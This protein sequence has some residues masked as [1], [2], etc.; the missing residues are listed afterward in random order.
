MSI[1]PPLLIDRFCRYLAKRVNA[2][3]PLYVA[4]TQD[5]SNVLAH[6]NTLFE[7]DREAAKHPSELGLALLHIATLKNWETVITFLI[8]NGFN[9][10]QPD[11]SGTTPL[12]LATTKKRFNQLLT[13]GADPHAQDLKGR[14]PALLTYLQGWV[15]FPNQ[16]WIIDG[17]PATI[18]TYSKILGR[19][20]S[21]LPHWQ[22]ETRLWIWLTELGLPL[23]ECYAIFGIRPP[24]K[25]KTVKVDFPDELI[26]LAKTT[27]E[28]IIDT[29]LDAMIKTLT[30]Q[31]WSGLEIFKEP[32]LSGQTPHYSVR[33]LRPIPAGTLVALYV[34]KIGIR[35]FHKPNPEYTFEEDDLIVDA[36]TQGSGAE[37]IN[38]SFPNLIPLTVEYIGVCYTCLVSTSLIVPG[39]ALYYHYGPEHPITQHIELNSQARDQWL[40]HAPDT[41]AFIENLPED[42]LKIVDYLTKRHYLTLRKTKGI[43][44]L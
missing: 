35:G 21:P 14:T 10:S 16:K 42:P 36:A 28:T 2:T 41:E 24:E 32:R 18:E 43:F 7:Q 1:S 23:K 22:P 38:D 31:T 34:G 44:E 9:P 25:P 8:N 33:T 39:E 13:A 11:Q 27:I 29:Q 4:L 5:E 30:H 26:Q 20:Y 15:S 19:T 37:L 3:S 12:H 6:L 17:K 40:K